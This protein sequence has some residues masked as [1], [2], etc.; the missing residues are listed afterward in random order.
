MR[1][2]WLGREVHA[3]RT[4]LFDWN[5]RVGWRLARAEDLVAYGT[6]RGDTCGCKHRVQEGDLSL[7]KEPGDTDDTPMPTLLTSMGHVLRHGRTSLALESQL[8]STLFSIILNFSSGFLERESRAVVGKTYVGLG[9]V[10]GWWHADRRQD[11]DWQ[12]CGFRDG[13]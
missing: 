9:V 13:Q 2:H 11:V 7:N 5:R 1:S 12:I 6:C 4:M 10:L 8:R 3:C